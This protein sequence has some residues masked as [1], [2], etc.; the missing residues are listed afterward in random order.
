MTLNATA[1]HLL[2]VAEEK[3]RTHGFNGFSYKDLQKE[4]GIKTS[5]VHYYFPTKQDLALALI[6]R[7]T[8][9]W[10]E[11]LFEINHRYKKGLARLEALVRLYAAD[12]KTNK[13][14]LSGSLASEMSSLSSQVQ[15]ELQ[16]FFLLIEM[17]VV[18]A[19]NTAL[20][21]K[22][23]KPH[24]NPHKAAGLWVALLEGAS[25][26]TRLNGDQEYLEKTMD[27]ALIQIAELSVNQQA[28][29]PHL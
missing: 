5:S 19:L 25:L 28:Q 15:L 21:H 4:V 23:I 26:V 6:K 20:E 18:Q 22:E 11:H 24:I 2:D 12:L 7:T 14:S 16:E 17:W 1:Q 13:L 9:Q 29:K 8:Q 27:Q 3:I 10:K